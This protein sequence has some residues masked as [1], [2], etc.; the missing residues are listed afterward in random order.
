MKGEYNYSA[1]NNI[2]NIPKQIVVDLKLLMLLT[3]WKRLATPVLE[4][5]PDYKDFYDF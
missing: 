2:K 4:I 5:I 1:C 3:C